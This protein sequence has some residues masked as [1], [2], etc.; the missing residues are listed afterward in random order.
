MG[1]KNCWEDWGYEK[2]KEAGVGGEYDKSIDTNEIIKEYMKYYKL[3]S[4][5]K[6]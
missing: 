4:K 3:I 6:K 5:L 1:E 2:E